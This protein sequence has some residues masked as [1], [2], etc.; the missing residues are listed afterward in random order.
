TV[1]ANSAAGNAAA[2]VDS[3]GNFRIDGAPSGTVR[4]GARTGQMFGGNNRSAQAQTIQL[5]PGGT[6][7][8]DLEFKSDTTVRGRVISNNQPVS[9][10]T[11][12]FIPRA[13]RSQTS[14]SVRSDS[15]GNYEITGLDDG[16]YNVQVMDMVNLTPYTTTYTVSGSG[17]FDI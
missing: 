7:T 16:Q 3:S 14:A 11:V 13:G 10:A 17:T 4:V 12:S 8:V 5:D 6:A 15:S 2:P 1:T 9:S